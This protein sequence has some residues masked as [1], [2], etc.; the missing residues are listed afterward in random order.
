MRC[1]KTM[2]IEDE[3]RGSI[4]G[5]CYATKSSV[6]DWICQW[7]RGVPEGGLML[8]G[9]ALRGREFVMVGVRRVGLTAVQVVGWGTGA[10]S[11]S[12]SLPSAEVEVEVEGGEGTFEMFRNGWVGGK[13]EGRGRR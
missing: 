11:L 8:H 13:V 9:S 6:V 5:H 2:L 3:T 12:L 4:D 1:K 10:L 7:M